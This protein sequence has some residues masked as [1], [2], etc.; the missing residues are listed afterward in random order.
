[1]S[2]R[3]VIGVRTARA[4][5]VDVVVLVEPADVLAASAGDLYVAMTRPTRA[6]RV[7]HSAPLPAGW[8]AD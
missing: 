2:T 6:L 4:A 5:T 7:L 8:A 3:P 1:M